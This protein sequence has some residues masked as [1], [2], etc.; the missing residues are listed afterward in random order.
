MALPRQ[1]SQFGMAGEAARESTA[2]GLA[3]PKRSCL[4]PVK[5]RHGLTEAVNRPTIV[6]LGQVDSAEGA[7]RQCVQ[8]DIPAVHGEGALGG[9]DGLVIRAPAAVEIG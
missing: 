8:D 3:W 2:G 9:S 4:R 5:E 1:T 7:V 6:S